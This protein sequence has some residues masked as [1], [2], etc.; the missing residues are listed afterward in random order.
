M[1]EAVPG[2]EKK[3]ILISGLD[4]AGKT[5]LLDLI[6]GKLVKEVEMQPTRG[7]SRREAEIMGQSIS[8]QDLGGQEQYRTQYEE[9]PIKVYPGTDAFI[10]VVDLQDR[11]RYYVSLGYFE[12]TLG[13]FDGLGAHPRVFVL[14][15]KF[16]HAFRASYN[17]TK[18]SVREEVNSMKDRF[19]TSAR[20][21]NFD[22]FEFYKTSIFDEWSCYAAF[23]DV[24]SSLVT[25]LDSVQEYLDNLVTPDVSL[26]LLLDASGNLIAKNLA[27]TS[28]ESAIEL[29]EL[30]NRAIA[31]LVELRN[32]KT[33]EILGE[34]NLITFDVGD[35]EA[36]IRGFQCDDKTYFLILAK[37]TGDVKDTR[38]I[39]DNF[40]YS[41][42][43]FL[44]TLIDQPENNEEQTT[45]D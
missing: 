35:Q 4:N 36:F 6:Q 16:D 11:D 37:Y 15:H 30:A 13:L 14:F 31:A 3:K 42:S 40:T 33:G 28:M 45:D 43:V 26:V 1:S 2:I 19:V 29:L 20:K 32:T 44:P 5:S 34:T 41:L 25:H 21:Y 23:Y 12:T 7:I 38:E 22:I 39:L 27:G 9:N 10:F 24:W 18:K 17:D 8:I